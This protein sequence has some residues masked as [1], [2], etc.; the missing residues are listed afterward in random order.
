MNATDADVVI[1]TLTEEVDRLRRA[2]EFI[3][4]VK[5]T[6]GYRNGF[7]ALKWHAKTTLTGKVSPV[8][9]AR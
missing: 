1:A 3:A 6:D 8:R 7:Y 2:L 4:T 5:V 9:S